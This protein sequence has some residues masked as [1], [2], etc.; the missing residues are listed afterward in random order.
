[1]K[2][3]MN[4][5]VTLGT[6]DGA[7]I[8]IAQAAGEENEFIFGARIEELDAIADSY[9]PMALYEKDAR[10]RR[11]VDSLTDAGFPDEDGALK[12]LKTSLLEGA[13]WHKP[14][15]YYVLKDF[16]S[17]RDARLKALRLYRDD[18]AAFSMMALKNVLASGIFSSDRTIAQYCEEIWKI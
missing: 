6:W 18:P 13:S 11:A 3:M 1:M 7:N 5:A 12:E 14:D 17:Y 16:E 15:H 4:G 2:L 9:D 10:L 8:E